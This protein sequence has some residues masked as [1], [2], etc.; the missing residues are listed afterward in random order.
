MIGAFCDLAALSNIGPLAGT[1]LLF[2]TVTVL[3]HGAIIFGIGALFRVDLDI[4][5]IAS[6]ANIGGSTSALALARSLGRADLVVPAVLVGSLGY[7]VGTYLGFFVGARC[8]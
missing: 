7:G 8:L 2:V 5:A 1:L 4:T 6:Q 3:I